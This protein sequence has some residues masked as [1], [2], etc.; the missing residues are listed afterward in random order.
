MKQLLRI[1]I[2]AA[3]A[4][5]LFSAQ[6]QSELDALRHTQTGLSGT[7]RAMG[8]GGA[9]HAVGAD[10]SA[11]TSN[12]AG[13]GFFRGSTY[14]GTVHFRLA[15]DGSQ[16][17]GQSGEG[18]FQRL[19]LSSAGIAFQS[20]T[21]SLS[22][23]REQP[24]GLLS[25]TIAF[26]FNQTESYFREVKA[27]NAFNPFSSFGEGFVDRAN[28]TPPDRL[29]FLDRLAFDL[30]V[31]DTIVLRDGQSYYTAASEGKVY[32]T[33]QRREEGHRNSWYAAAGANYNDRVY[34]G[35]TLGLQSVRYDQNFI[36]NEAD[37]DN[38]YEFYYPFDDNLFPL[39]L[40]TNEIRFQDVFSTR[41]NGFEARAG[42]IVRAADA[43]RVGLAVQSPTYY[44]LTDEFRS[45]LTHSLTL[46]AGP[47]EFSDDTDV[48][49]FEYT[50]TTPLRI[51]GGA[52][53]Q[54]GKMA[55][56]SVEGEWLDYGSSALRSV[57]RSINDPGYYSFEEENA[58]IEAL[59]RPAL[60]LRG[61]AELRLDMFRLRGGAAFHGSPLSE[62]ASQYQD[63]QDLANLLSIRGGRRFLTAGAGI[64]QPNFYLDV[65]YV[66][67]TQQD[68]FSP[69]TISNPDVFQPTVVSDIRT[70]QVLLTLGYNF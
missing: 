53:L 38:L 17:L 43:L 57:E 33:L 35:L 62:A 18:S 6:A 56:I 23:S 36:F 54:A 9:F 2:S 19:G 11:A 67:Q 52:V 42:V 13:L 32:Q 55:L 50:L 26:G 10:L 12:P 20:D 49:Q 5:S 30:L 66:Y 65:A 34:F 70:H 61:G 21:Y 47:Q 68:K 24:S 8:M 46:Q 59:Y 16:F 14:A 31:I 4:G 1:G 39:Q 40:P 22:D 27:E 60:N 15:Q 64:R 25:Y 45:F 28:G 48:A 7:A 69:Y 51:S 44:T 41:G 37:R 29:T 63:Y 58:R 3:L